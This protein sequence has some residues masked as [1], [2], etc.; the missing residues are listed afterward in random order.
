M[1]HNSVYRLG[2]TFNTY[3]VRGIFMFRT[4][5]YIRFKRNAFC[6]SSVLIT[7]ILYIKINV[8]Y[9]ETLEIVT[10][11]IYTVLDL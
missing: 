2:V 8:F 9:I 3:I 4:L 11:P 6:A 10:V 7:Y 5:M 1:D